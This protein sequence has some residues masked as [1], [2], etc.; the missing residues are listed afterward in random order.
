MKKLVKFVAT[1]VALTLIG[2]PAIKVVVRTVLADEPI[3]T[4]QN[5][6]E[7]EEV[8]SLT[9]AT[10]TTTA[11]TADNAVGV[12]TSASA[13]VKDQTTTSS[14]SNVQLDENGKYTPNYK[15]I[16]SKEDLDKMWD[17]A[18]SNPS[19]FGGK[20]RIPEEP[21]PSEPSKPSEP[22]EP[23]PS[24]PSEPSEPTP[25]KPEESKSSSSEEPKSSSSS[26]E[27]KKVEEKKP[28]PT[29]GLPVTGEEKIVDYAMMATGFI[30]LLFTMRYTT[31]IAFLRGKY[32]I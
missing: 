23:E 2:I 24:K 10:E 21:T 11:S 25:S 1:I 14:G 31:V 13:E 32:K 12:D 20:G 18:E 6:K 17:E 28:L 9:E 4:V 29:A 3:T 5:T 30:I 19:Q 26:S 16:N 15:S 27:V 7:A 22:S 8:V